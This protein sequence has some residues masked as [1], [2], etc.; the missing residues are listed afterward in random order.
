MYKKGQILNDFSVFS[1]EASYFK[2]VFEQKG[3]NGAARKIGQDPANISR[4]LAR[5]E[6]KIGKKLFT[7]HKTGMNP[8]EV[9]QQLYSALSEAQNSFI[10]SMESEATTTRT[11]RIGFS[12]TIGY[13]HFSAHLSKAIIELAL[14][15][16]FTIAKSAELAELLKSRELDFVMAPNALKFP[17]LIAKKVGSE[18]LVLCSRSGAL[19]DQ[20]ILNPDLIGLEKFIQSIPY[21]KRWMM[22]DYFVMTKMTENLPQLM[23]VLPEGLLASHPHL[24]II[25]TFRHEGNITA[26]TWP[27][28]VGTE[29]LKWI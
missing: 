18:N 13:S 8:T 25:N 20:I 28:S 9:A 29:L 23:A 12:A 16:I 6:K 27:G 17:G 14:Q 19:Q 2:L 22:K 1:L 5:L 4:L 26:L 21:K 11:I 7:R 10:H 3:I 24:K 15:P